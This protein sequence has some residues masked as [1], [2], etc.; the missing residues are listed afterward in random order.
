[1][2]K[3][4]LQSIY[5]IKDVKIL[6]KENFFAGS[7]GKYSERNAKL[8][9]NYTVLNNMPRLLIETFSICGILA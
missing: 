8:T 3:W 4:K 5:G 1:M 7:F 6:N 2:G 9:T